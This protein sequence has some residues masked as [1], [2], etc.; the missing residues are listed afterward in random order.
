MAASTC[1]TSSTVTPVA[2]AI[3][4]SVWVRKPFES[5]AP[6]TWSATGCRRDGRSACRFQVRWSS[7]VK[8]ASARA[9][10]SN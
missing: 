10:G 8:S 5:S 1:S 4:A 3:S 2:S 9:I 7:S 6:M